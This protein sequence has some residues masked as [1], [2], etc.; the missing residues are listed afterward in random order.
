MDDISSVTADQNRNFTKNFIN[1][2]R[3]KNNVEKLSTIK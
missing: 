3:L 1:T 2:Y